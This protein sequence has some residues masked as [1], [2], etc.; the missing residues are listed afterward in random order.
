MSAIATEPIGS[1][2]ISR[3]PRVAHARAATVGDVTERLALLGVADIDA[4]ATLTP[5]LAAAAAEVAAASGIPWCHSDDDPPVALL[6]L[7]ARVAGVNPGAGG[8]HTA[9]LRDRL[10]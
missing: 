6:R 3:E 7:M 8:P 1:H 5:L 10:P 2:W 9:R 4:D